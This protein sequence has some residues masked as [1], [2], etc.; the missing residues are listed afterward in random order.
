MNDTRRGITQR[1]LAAVA[2][3]ILGLGSALIGLTSSASAVEGDQPCVPSAGTPASYTA[4][5]D[6][7]G[8]I[9][10][11]NDAPPAPDTDLVKYLPAGTQKH[12]TQEYVAPTPATAGRWENL[13]WYIWTGGPRDTA[14]DLGDGGWHGP[15]PNTPNGAPHNPAPEPAVYGT[16]GDNGQGSWFKYDGDFV[17]GAEGDPGQEEQSH[18]DYLWQKQVRSSV[19]GTDPVI[20]DGEQEPE[21][22]PDGTDKAET[23]IPEGEDVSWCDIDVLDNEGGDGG[24]GDGDGDT[25]TGGGGGGGPE[26]LGIAKKAPAAG[27]AAAPAAAAAAAAPA[28]APTAVAAGL[29]GGGQSSNSSTLWILAGG[30]FAMAGLVMGF[31]PAT[32]RGKRS[33]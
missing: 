23:T 32:A 12:V 7:G 11:H 19:P 33:I 27:Q 17:E 3:L 21:V 18:T 9:T 15:Q 14:P 8:V 28:A 30:A 22:C 29:T 5:A 24:D 25:T 16:S 26:V 31:A 1:A 13:A 6:E 10:T 20:C 2:M 4:W